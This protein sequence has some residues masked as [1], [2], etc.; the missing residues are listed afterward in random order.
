MRVCLGVPTGSWDM[1]VAA[2]RDDTE[3]VVPMR[4]LLETRLGR[5]R[6]HSVT[7]RAECVRGSSEIELRHPDYCRGS[8]DQPA[9]AEQQS[10]LPSA[11]R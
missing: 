4:R 10:G 1:A 6:A 2:C 5:N 8:E 11:H 9:E 3:V 7:R